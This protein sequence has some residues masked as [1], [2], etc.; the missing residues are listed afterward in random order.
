M[1]EALHS[2]PQIDMGRLDKRR[3]RIDEIESLNRA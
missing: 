2:H 1:R 3:L